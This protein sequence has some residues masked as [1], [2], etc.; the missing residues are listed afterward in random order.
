MD[1]R[2]PL[3]VHLSN[4]TGPYAGGVRRHRYT[5]SIRTWVEAH[6]D[7]RW[8]RITRSLPPLSQFSM[9]INATRQ[10]IELLQR[11]GKEHLD[12]RVEFLFCSSEWVDTNGCPSISIEESNCGVLL[13]CIQGLTR[14]GTPAMLSLERATMKLRKRRILNCTWHRIFSCH[15]YL[16]TLNP[17]IEWSVPSSRVC[18]KCRVW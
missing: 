13:R 11:P 17:E 7:F 6:P 8:T 12:W 5:K 14:K 2:L 10:S 3:L 15:E 1:A 9:A 4:A 18:R 16:V